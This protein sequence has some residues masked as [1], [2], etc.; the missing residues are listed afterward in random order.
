MLNPTYIIDPSYTYAIYF[1]YAL[2]GSGDGFVCLPLVFQ[3]F[4]FTMSRYVIALRLPLA[5]NKGGF[6]WAVGMP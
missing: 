3:V 5:T 6:L 2:V 1:R 4:P